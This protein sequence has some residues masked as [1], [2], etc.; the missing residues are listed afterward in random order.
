MKGGMKLNCVY[1][2]GNS[3]ANVPQLFLQKVNYADFSV[4]TKCRLDLKEDGDETGFVVFGKEYGYVCVVRSNG[5]NYLEIRKGSIGGGEDETLCRSQPYDDK[6]V[7]F[8]MTARRVSSDK[9][10]YKFTFGGS[11]FTHKFYA[12]PAVWTGAKIGVYARS[13]A[14]SV[15]C[16]TFKFFRVTEN[17]TVESRVKI[18]L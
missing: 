17:R 12:T 13:S 6:Y 2:G 4:K 1:Y 8:Q 3:L 9:F 15:G 16:S 18:T 7:T 11:A 14:Q 10:L 5:R